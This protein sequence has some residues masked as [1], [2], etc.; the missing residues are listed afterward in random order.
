MQRRKRLL[1]VGAINRP[2]ILAMFRDVAPHADLTFLE[3]YFHWGHASK[4]EH[5]APYGRLVH[6]H[7]YRDADAVI[8]DVRPDEV[9]LFYVSSLNQV[10]LK[11][12]AQAR[13]IRTRH[14][15][16]GHRLRYEDSLQ[17]HVSRRELA[18]RFDRAKLR[19]EH[20][21][22][23]RN[24]AFFLR[25]VVTAARPIRRDL[26]AFGA[27]VYLRGSSP[28]LLRR[29]GWLRQP[30]EYLAFSPETFEY[31]RV[32]DA[33]E[34][35]ARPVRHL[36]IPYFDRL[37]G[38]A[39]RVEERN[40]LLIDHQFHNGGLFGWNVPFRRRWADE[41]LRTLQG[42]GRRLFVK[43]HPGDRS[44][45]WEPH[46][47][48]G[49]VERVDDASLPDVVARTRVVLGTFSTMQLPLAGLAHTVVLTLEI[50]PESGHFPS[51]R[52]VE[53]GVARAVR[54]FSELGDALA[55][56]TELHAEQSVHKA[57]FVAQYLHRMDGRAG[58]RLR[59]ALLDG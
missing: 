21:I 42:A 52:F 41:L 7:E 5:Y 35:G 32:Q 34:D 48:A 47:A 57:S 51:R 59:E 50:H 44:A 53:S 4:P 24:H 29:Y 30:D 58:E 3:Y 26:A 37:C 12:A 27:S 45:V 2:D 10:A 46:V 49:S 8:D 43:L 11:L 13:G 14:L 9:V 1:V 25:S 38:L 19:R 54:S 23:A 15:E 6:W 39:P 18:Q 36:G 17:G 22:T 55:S 16:H 40:V 33:V 31:H 56:S 20:T 28:D